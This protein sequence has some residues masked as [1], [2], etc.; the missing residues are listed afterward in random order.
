MKPFR[1]TLQALLT[2][3]QRQENSAMEEYGRAL[4]QQHSGEIALDAGDRAMTAGWTALRQMVESVCTAEDITRQ[5][6]YCR[7]LVEHREDALKALEVAKLH[8]KLAMQQMMDARRQRELVD[9]CR[10]K[11]HDRHRKQLQVV[12]NKL[13]DEMALRRLVPMLSLNCHHATMSLR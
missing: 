3:R 12:E 9:K 4:H 6:D 11:Q 2:L 5:R 13:N 7:L 8:V 10:D 1:F